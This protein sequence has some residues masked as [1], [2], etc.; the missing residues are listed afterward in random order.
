MNKTVLITGASRGIGAATA[1][2]FA[3]NGYN[4]VLH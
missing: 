4:V 2:L 1:L 3:Q